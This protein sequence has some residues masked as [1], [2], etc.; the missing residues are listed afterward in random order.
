[1]TDLSTTYLGLALRNPLAASASPYTQTVAGARQLEDA[2]L[3][4][5]VMHSLFEEQ[6]THESLELDHYL[7]R[8]TGSFSEAM[9]FFPDLATYAVGPD[10][11]LSLVRQIK[12][13][14]DVPVIGSLNGVSSGGWVHHAKLIEEAGADAIELNIYY[15]PTDVDL[16]G[17]EL[18]RTYADLVRTVRA[19]VRIPVAVKLAPFFTALANV[20]STLVDA[21]ANGL[22]LFNRFYQPDIDLVDMEVVPGIELSQAEEMR[23][24]MR[25]IAILSARLTCDFALSSGIGSAEG[26][27]KA[28]MA[29]A[30]VAMMT[31]ELLR[32]GLGRPRRMLAD[33]EGWMEA[34]EYASVRQ[35]RGSMNQ[36]S[37][38]EP[39]A[40][41]RA[42]Y[43]K[44][45]R[46]FDR[47]V[48]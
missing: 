6:I 47:E 37:V 41:E 34:H 13:A 43:M 21:G 3:A 7:L 8:A 22:V 1:M 19:E 10:K 36:S 5:I 23:L 28:I 48:I 46:T 4:A 29:G 26:A 44:A 38:S 18:E 35:M 40:F 9:D 15:V 31:S 25:W 2:G 17:A 30:N 42:N 27:L 12:E 11:Y 14:V 45:L 39:A 20:A 16:T 33:M 24:P 32:G